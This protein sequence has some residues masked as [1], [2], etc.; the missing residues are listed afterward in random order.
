MCPRKQ[1]GAPGACTAQHE[2]H[3][4]AYT[5]YTNLVDRRQSRVHVSRPMRKRHVS[6]SVHRAPNI[7]RAP[8]AWT[9]PMKTRHVSLRSTVH[10]TTSVHRVHEPVH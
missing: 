10:Q 3:T 5:W 8:G 6:T 2:A 1:F 7:F 9:E 4:K